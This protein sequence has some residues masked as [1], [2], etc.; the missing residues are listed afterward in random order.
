MKIKDYDL[1]KS[2]Y[3]GLCKSIG[4]SCGCVARLTLT[5]DCTFLSIVLSSLILRENVNIDIGRCL[6]HPTKKKQIVKYNPI[7]EYS[8]MCN[9][10]LAYN[11][12]EDNYIDDKD[13]KAV[14]VR[15]ALKPGYKKA[16][17]TMPVLAGFIEKS[18]SEQRI[19][20]SEKCDNID[21]I[22]DK[23]AKIV[24]MLFYNEELVN[25]ILTNGLE[26]DNAYSGALKWLG[27]NVGKWI[28]IA[29]C[30]DDI[31]DDLKNDRY[32][33]LRYRYPKK[34]IEDEPEYKARI[35]GEV[36]FI[37]EYCLAEAAKAID[38]LEPEHAKDIIENIIYAGMYK[39]NLE[40][41][42]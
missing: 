19:L 36:K 32:N 8:A 24:E 39:K 38:V 12:A 1:F 17:R 3:C 33:P 11:K 31:T 10:L 42:K 14:A 41:M 7:V 27:Y 28:Y 23:F 20:E 30:C 4:K 21:E 29:D 25:I 2:H 35:S 40:V 9:V 37:L 13:L 34:D 18:L 16:S 15:T 6:L 22:A 26:F 5:Y